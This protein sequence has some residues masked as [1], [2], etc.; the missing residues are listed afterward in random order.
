MPAGAR[1]SGTRARGPAPPCCTRVGHTTSPAA[2]GRMHGMTGAR[3]GVLARMGMMIGA[4][5][6]A[7]ACR[8]RAPQPPQQPVRLDSIPRRVDVHLYVARDWAWNEEDTL[9][10]T[11]VNA[12]ERPLAGDLNLFVGS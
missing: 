1:K 11:V 2:T 4:A 8:D 3:R 12:T 5:L 10:V 7:A 6:L 9:R